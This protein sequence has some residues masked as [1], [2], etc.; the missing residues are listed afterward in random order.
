M[1]VFVM[2]ENWHG[3][4]AAIQSLGR[5]GHRLTVGVE[6]TASVHTKSDFVSKVIMTPR[7]PDLG[8]RARVL[9]E[10]VQREGFDLVVPQSDE[11][12]ETVALAAE[13]NPNCPAFVTSDVAT[14]RLTRDRNATWDLCR[15]LGLGVPRSRP[16][17][18]RTVAEAA[19]DIG[20]PCYLKFSQTIA[21]DGVN[22][23]HGPEDLAPLLP[24]IE[25]AGD[26]QLQEVVEGDFVGVTG[27]ALNGELIDS[28]AFQVPADLSFAGTPPFAWR[29]D[30]PEATRWL[31]ALVAHL[32]WTGG[33]DVDCL[34]TAD[35][36]LALLEINPRMS[37]TSHFA[38]VCG[39]D[40]P[41]GFLRA[42]GVPVEGPIWPPQAPEMFISLREE[43]ALRNRSGGMGVARRLRRDNHFATNMYAGDR[44]HARAMRKYLVRMRLKAWRQMAW[45]G[46][47]APFGG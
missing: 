19:Q 39:V 31:R 24:A 33:I 16:V 30:D 27:F 38:L 21:S 32:N 25:Q 47:T 17:T 28:F 3:G 8:E 6:R 35:G 13:I 18:G 46:L 4:M 42:V 23:L 37:G 20:F 43:A 26:A 34:R 40:L 12:A 7:D 36:S 1:H 10:L 11:D 45:R 15:R 29:L 5:R 14:V 41:A 22:L 2:R 44:G 9:C